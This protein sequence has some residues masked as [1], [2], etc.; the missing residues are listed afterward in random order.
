MNTNVYRT[1]EDL[2]MR[3]RLPRVSAQLSA[4]VERIRDIR[5]RAN[6]ESLP[7]VLAPVTRSALRRG[8]IE[9]LQETAPDAVHAPVARRIARKIGEYLLWRR[10]PTIPVIHE[11]LVLAPWWLANIPGEVFA[12]LREIGL[13]YILNG[14]VQPIQTVWRELLDAPLVFMGHCTCRSARVSEDLH[15]DRGEVYLTVGES[16]QRLL[17]DR[18][19]D[20]FAFLLARHGEAIP[21]CDPAFLAIGHELLEA[22][23]TTPAAYRLDSLLTRTYP[24]WE[25]LPVIEPY[26][27]SWIRSLHAN[28]KARLL[29]KELAFELATILYL[30]KGVVFSTMRF[31]DQPYCICSCPSPENGGGCVLTNWHYGSGSDASLLPNDAEHGRRRAATGEVLPCNRFPIRSGRA[32]IGCGCLHEHPDPRGIRTVL[33]EAEHYL[34]AA[35]PPHPARPGR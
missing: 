25:F 10:E 24:F 20:R 23:R 12:Q 26:T 34:P 31:F 18:F 15:G 2:A 19:V 11:L 29:H 21:D 7:E 6:P 22:R 3:R 32:C 13:G 4:L 1:A 35:T 17:L 14:A 16:D 5:L 30:G 28:H 8:L 33:D 9:A 27:P